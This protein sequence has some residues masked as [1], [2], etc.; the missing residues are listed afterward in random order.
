VIQ[1]YASQIKAG[2]SIQIVSELDP[3]EVVNAKVDFVETQLNSSEKTNQIRVYLNNAQRQ[4]PIGLRLEGKIETLSQKGIW[5]P[6]QA[7]VSLGSH[8]LVFVKKGN[9]FQSTKVK[10][11]IE[12]KG[13]IQILSGI[14][15]EEEVAENGYYLMDSESF[16]R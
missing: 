15:T 12:R 14:S 13:W 16:I 3:D 9:G 4:F 7:L 2:Q 8:Q 1:G 11:G 6:K 5:L 10:T